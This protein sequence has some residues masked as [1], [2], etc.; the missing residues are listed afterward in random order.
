MEDG[1]A[2]R[3][4]ARSCERLRSDPIALLGFCLLFI[5]VLQSFSVGLNECAPRRQNTSI[6]RHSFQSDTVSSVLLLSM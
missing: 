3:C 2:V 5:V 4:I 6:S 1:T